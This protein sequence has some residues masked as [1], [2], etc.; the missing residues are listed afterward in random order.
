M[1]REFL[2]VFFGVGTWADARDRKRAEAARKAASQ[3][4]DPPSGEGR[5]ERPQPL[6]TPPSDP[7]P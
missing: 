3:A 6:Q 7:T 2:A 1:L 5:D 4:E